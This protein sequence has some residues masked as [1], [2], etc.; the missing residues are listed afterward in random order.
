MGESPFRQRRPKLNTIL[1]HQLQSSV[2]EVNQELS[3]SLTVLFV[4][5][6]NTLITTISRSGRRQRSLRPGHR[7][8]FL[9]QY[10]LLNTFLQAEHSP[11]YAK[12]KS[13]EMHQL[14]SEPKECG[15]CDIDYRLDAVLQGEAPVSLQMIC[16]RSDCFARHRAWVC[17]WLPI[18][19]VPGW[20]RRVHAV[21]GARLIGI[22]ICNSNELWVCPGRALRACFCCWSGADTLL[23]FFHNL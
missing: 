11:D 12:K 6:D 8:V 3:H 21:A 5:Y 4:H 15:H 2:C 1:L 14:H 10:C 19:R 23:R 9:F 16:I 18:S 20:I 22:L 7:C 17:A 13:M